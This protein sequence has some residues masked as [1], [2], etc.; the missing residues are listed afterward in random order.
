MYQV[1]IDVTTGQVFG[2]GFDALARDARRAGAS[3]KDLNR[4]FRQIGKPMLSRARTAAPYKRGRL[5]KSI[6][7]QAKKQSLS[8]VADV[9]LE[10]IDGRLQGDYAPVRHW[11]RDG[12][13]G[14]KFLKNAMDDHMAEAYRGFAEGIS[15]L[16]YEQGW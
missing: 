9:P 3:A 13:S 16:L 8:L 5:Q 1:Q 10:K 12:R 4:I 14:S 11:G 15:R 2:R 6:K 7:I